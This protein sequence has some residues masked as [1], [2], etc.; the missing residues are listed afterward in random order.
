[1]LEFNYYLYIQRMTHIVCVHNFIAIQHISPVLFVYVLLLFFP[2][3]LFCSFVSFFVLLL[4]LSCVCVVL[5]L[6]IR[7]AVM[8]LYSMLRYTTFR[9]L[10]ILV[11]TVLRCLKYVLLHPSE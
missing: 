3:L 8:R 2:F 10:M 5:S 6:I 11:W 4:R 7:I 1:M 9:L